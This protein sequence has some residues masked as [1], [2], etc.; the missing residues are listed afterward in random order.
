MKAHPSGWVTIIEPH[1]RRIIRRDQIVAL[2]LAELPRLIIIS[3]LGGHELRIEE[4]KLESLLRILDS[5]LT[6]LSSVTWTRD[7]N[8]YW[9]AQWST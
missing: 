4:A 1:L 7:T 9:A 6:G 3:M 5:L 8:G 2:T